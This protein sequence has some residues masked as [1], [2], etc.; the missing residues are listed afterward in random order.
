MSYLNKIKCMRFLPGLYAYVSRSDVCTR[1]A[2][3]RLGKILIHPLTFSHFFV[4]P[5]FLYTMRNN[6]AQLVL[7]CF[8]VEQ[9]LFSQINMS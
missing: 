3:T 1:L 7:S 5:S 4:H 9:K 2:G 8:L 6:L